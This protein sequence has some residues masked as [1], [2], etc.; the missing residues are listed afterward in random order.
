MTLD[1]EIR[2]IFAVG[3]RVHVLVRAPPDA[4]LELDRGGQLGG[5]ELE[6]WLEQP[7]SLGSDGEPRLDLF[8]LALRNARDRPKLNE[9]ATVQLE[10]PPRAP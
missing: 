8:V 9:G 4:E 10:L 7:R 1:L 3:D 2:S 5:V 6:P